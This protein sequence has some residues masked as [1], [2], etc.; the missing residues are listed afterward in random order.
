M[1]ALAHVHGVCAWVCVCMLCACAWGACVYVHVCWG[2]PAHHVLQAPCGCQPLLVCLAL[3]ALPW[4]PAFP[5][6]VL[7]LLGVI[8]FINSAWP[9]FPWC[10]D[11]TGIPVIIAGSEGAGREGG[12][13]RELFCTGS[14]GLSGCGWFFFLQRYLECIESSPKSS[15]VALRWRRA[16]TVLLGGSYS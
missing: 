13:G 11:K 7:S 4:L 1:H 2:G 8:P 5:Y 12:G 14:S 9:W 3:A 6:P 10:S 15:P 16:S